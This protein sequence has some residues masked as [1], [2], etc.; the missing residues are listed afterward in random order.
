[1]EMGQ[2]GNKTQAERIGNLNNAAFELYHK[3][4]YLCQDGKQQS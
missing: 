1:M 4:D 2:A 3:K